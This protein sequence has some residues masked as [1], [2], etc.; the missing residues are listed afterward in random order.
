MII[1]YI[2]HS[3][4]KIQDKID[5]ENINLVIDPFD[6]SVNLKMPTLET[7]LVLIS[8]DHHDH[9][10]I[11][12]IK[13]NPLIINSPGEYDTKGV[14]IEGI[15]SFHDNK[16]GDERG[17]N[18]IF[19]IE[20]NDLSIAH[21]GDLGHILTAQHL[22]RLG[23]IDILLIPIGGIYTIDFKQAIEIINQ[24]EPRIII[25][26]H[27]RINDKEGTQE[28]DSLEKFTKELG[29]EVQEEEKLKIKKKE[30]PIDEMEL[31]VLKI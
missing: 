26:M 28:L 17:K 13:G 20:M 31:V 12:K 6:D 5:S 24:I 19:R 18:T 10:N 30:L 3:C 2:G 21:L 15:D 11:K 23:I 7:N 16:N 1:K 27:Y 25:P 4:F 29:L 22:D 9:N 8:H 14:M